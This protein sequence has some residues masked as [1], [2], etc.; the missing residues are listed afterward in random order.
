MED[1]LKNKKLN[2]A[3]KITQLRDDQKRQQTI[4]NEA[5]NYDPSNTKSYKSWLN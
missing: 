4:E 1:W 3:Y 2:E 5:M